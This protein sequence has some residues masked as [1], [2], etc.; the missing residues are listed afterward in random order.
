MAKKIEEYLSEQKE[1]YIKNPS[2]FIKKVQ[3]V[4]FQDVMNSDERSKLYE[5]EE[6][7][8]DHAPIATD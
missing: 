6:C 4:I 8:K 5:N 7:K 1:T 2:E 3:E